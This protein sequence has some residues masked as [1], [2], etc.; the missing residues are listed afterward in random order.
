MRHLVEIRLYN[1]LTRRIDPLLPKVPGKVGIY[2]CGPTVYSYAHIGNMRTYVFCDVLRRSL[3][4]LGYDVYHV[5]NITDVGHLTD[6]GDQ[7]EDKME[8]GCRREGQSAWDIAK[9]YTEAFFNHAAQLHIQRPHTICK[10][11][12]HIPEQIEL[13]KQLEDKGYVYKTSDGVYFDTSKFDRYAELARLDTQGLREGQRVDLGEKKSKTDFALWKFAK[14]GEKRQMEWDSPWGRGFP[15]WHIECSAM[16]M[17]YL[18]QELDIHTGGVDHIPIHHTNE[19]AQSECAT[20]RKPFARHW[21]HGEFLLLDDSVKMSKSTGNILTVDSLAEKGFDPRS[22]RFLL[23]Q[24]HYRKQLHFSYETLT[25]A[26]KGLERL[27][28]QTTRLS[29]T[30]AT[31]HQATEKSQPPPLSAAAK[32]Y[33]DQFQQALVQDLNMP[34]ALAELHRLVSDPAVAQ[35][36]KARLVL[37][38]DEVLALDLS[39]P[40]AQKEQAIPDEF[41][42]ML[43]ARNVARQNKD[44]A[45]ADRIRKELLSSGYEILDSPQG[46][47]LKKKPIS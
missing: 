8:V 41:V 9:K 16:A 17:R 2:S 12:D 5:M 6:D 14:P 20:G 26:Q 15:G 33:A 46:T 30:S 21:L 7:G 13:V 34:Q 22:Y 25:A 42:K 37:E 27:L 11:T 38:W 45:E 10:A 32:T 40:L 1:T 44:W 43:A 28:Q 39:T 47:S 35:E 3:K 4:F 18:G 24:T 29:L 19:I 31:D 23:L 36:E